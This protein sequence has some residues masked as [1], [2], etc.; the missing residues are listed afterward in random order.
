MDKHI[1]TG[2]NRTGMKASPLDAEAL[3]ASLDLQTDTPAP[4]PTADDLRAAYQA[5]AEPVGSM[6]PPASVKGAIG[7]AAQALSGNKLHV[8]LDKLGERAAYERTGTR[9]YDAMLRKVANAEALLPGLTLEAVREIRNEEASHF[10]LLTEAIEKLGGD[11]TVQTPCADVAG[12]KGMGLVQAMGD[13]RLTMA[14][15]LDTLL[16]AELIDEACWE[17]LIELA[18]D[19]GQ[20]ELANRFTSALAAENRH[21][22]TVRGWA[23][24]AVSEAA[25][26]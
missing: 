25:S 6:P 22:A 13:P 11:P 7:T 14:Q 17:M 5:G 23:A 21:V 4:V 10:L 15:A 24:A 8:F 9:L 12:V 1:T 19:F 16:A 18:S 2:L 3:L 26:I 20:D